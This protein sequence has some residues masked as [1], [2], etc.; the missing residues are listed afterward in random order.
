MFHFADAHG[1]NLAGIGNLFKA[2]AIVKVL[3][4][5]DESKAYIQN[6]DTN[7][8]LENKFANIDVN[9]PIAAHNANPSAH[10][11]IRTAVSNAQSKADSA[12]TA[13]ANAQS[14]AD[15]AA[16]AAANAQSTADS[17]ATAAANAQSTANSAATA[18]ANAQ[19]TANSAATAAAN[20]QTTAANAQTTADSKAPMYTYG[21]TDMTAG[22]SAL[23]TG[24]LYFVYE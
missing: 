9:G 10:S 6:A 5:L 15:S 14:T 23:E 13:A 1:N 3:L 18:A 16:T 22:T 19:S 17:A 11:D 2:G 7:A 24:K 21:T 8:Y 4:S 20:A 12:A